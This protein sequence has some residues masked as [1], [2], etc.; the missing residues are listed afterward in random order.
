MIP[1]RYAN[2]PCSLTNSGIGVLLSVMSSTS[3]QTV[4]PSATKYNSLKRADLYQD[5]NE[6]QQ[7]K[8]R[9]GRLDLK[10]ENLNEVTV[11]ATERQINLHLVQVQ[12][13]IAA[14]AL[15]TSRSLLI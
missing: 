14:F 1:S 7:K 6:L 13:Q 5:G 10:L 12:N 3:I 9:N 2:L 4:P 11:D 15:A 8:N